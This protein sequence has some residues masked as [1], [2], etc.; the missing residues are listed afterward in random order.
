M[1]VDSK[2]TSIANDDS[3]YAGNTANLLYVGSGGFNGWALEINL[4]TGAQRLSG[5]A[6]D[7]TPLSRWHS[8]TS[9]QTRF[10]ASHDR[11][12]VLEPR[13]ES[14]RLA[15]VDL[16]TGTQLWSVEHAGVQE[17]S[18]AV[19]APR[20][21]TRFLVICESEKVHIFDREN[22]AVIGVIGPSEVGAT[23][24]PINRPAPGATISKPSASEQLMIQPWPKHLWL[25]LF[26]IPLAWL[27]W[28][29]ARRRPVS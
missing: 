8:R 7:R 24:R 26:A 23:L 22:G 18:P 27:L 1:F 14:S 20:D 11:V 15:C 5:H 16:T 25:A 12:W 10:I 3:N 4:D 2:G 17:P 13:L 21:A 9:P 6:S 28:R 19:H 29:L